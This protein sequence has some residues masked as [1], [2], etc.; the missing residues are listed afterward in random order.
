MKEEKLNLIVCGVGGQG[1]VTVTNIIGEAC[2][3]ADKYVLSAEM[4]GL[5]QRGGSIVIH[6][7]IGDKWASPLIPY[8]EADI[9]LSLELIESLRYI[10]FLKPKGILLYNDYMILPPKEN[11]LF[12]MKKKK[13]LFTEEDVRNVLNETD[14]KLIAIPAYN[15]AKN[16][17]NPKTVNTVMLGALAAISY[18]PIENEFMVKAIETIAPAKALKQNID[19]FYKG[20]DLVKKNFKL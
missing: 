8:G 14:A 7:R 5:A 2:L 10:Y 3:L 13:K 6:Q 9:I 4:H 17:G 16:V 20:F 15:I 11:N 12:V 1:V 18:F 19:A